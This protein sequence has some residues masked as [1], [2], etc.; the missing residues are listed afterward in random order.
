LAKAGSGLVDGMN[1]AGAVHIMEGG[2]L[3]LEIGDGGSGIGS[4]LRFHSKEPSC[5]EHGPISNQY[6]LLA[7]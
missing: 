1:G 7:P 6:L 4:E 5:S 3:L 2:P